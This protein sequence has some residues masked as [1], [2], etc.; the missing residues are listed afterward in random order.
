MAQW[1]AS[2]EHGQDIRDRAFDFACYVVEFCKRLYDAGGVARLMTAQLLNCSTSVPAMLEEA[3]AAES[4][5]DF[6]SKCSIA[7]KEARES[8]VRLGVCRR[9]NVGPAGD[10]DKL[11]NE[12]NQIVAILTAIIRH[13]RRNTAGMKKTA[14]NARKVARVPNS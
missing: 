6:I 9:C 14:G 8:H 4:K 2:Y 10:G 12:A 7:L 1:L 13:T 11:V 5:R 3:R